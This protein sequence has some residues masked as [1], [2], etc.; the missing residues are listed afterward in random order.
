MTNLG[1]VTNLPQN[2]MGT[3]YHMLA[4][5]LGRKER[6]CLHLLRKHRTPSIFLFS[7]HLLENGLVTLNSSCHPAPFG[8]SVRKREVPQCSTQ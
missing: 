4:S 5:V 3:E 8:L 1:D 2:C 7:S 6:L